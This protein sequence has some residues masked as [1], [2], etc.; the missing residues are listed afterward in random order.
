MF[1]KSIDVSAYVKYAQLLCKLLNGFIQ[2]IGQQY[3]VQLIID[4]ATN[5]VVVGKLLMKRY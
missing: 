4:N 1:I 3:V 5:Y 2:E